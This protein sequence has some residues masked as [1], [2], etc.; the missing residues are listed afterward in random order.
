MPNPIAHPAVAVPFTRAGLVLSAL[1]IGS[2]APDFGYAIPLTN[3]YFMNTAL[4]LILFDVPAGSALLWLFHT[5]VKWPLLSAAPDSLQRRLFRPAR[6]FSFGP[7]KRFGM[8]VLS[9]LVGSITHVIWDSFTHE[10]GWMVEH[11]APLRISLE[12]MP[13]YAI[14]QVLGSV[15]GVCLLAYWILQWLPTASQSNELPA[16]FSSRV[17]MVFLVLVATSL[18]SFEGATIYAGFTPG[19]QLVREHGLVHGLTL[20]A[21]LIL[22]FYAGAYCLAW[23]IAFRR[24]IRPAR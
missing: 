21:V 20:T 5:F 15:F 12:G 17:R 16:R 3:P 1:V 13:L 24:T 10:W 8:I 2:I 6:E 4:G 11:F 14:L 22:S 7:P 9:L 23:M 19:T 18:V